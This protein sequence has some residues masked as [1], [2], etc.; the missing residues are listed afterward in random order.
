MQRRVGC[1]KI[2]EASNPIALLGPAATAPTVE[3]FLKSLT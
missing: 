1:K 3:A 2:L